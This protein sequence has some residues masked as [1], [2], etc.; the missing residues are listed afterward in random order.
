M[1]Q[2]QKLVRVRREQ[3]QKRRAEQSAALANN[4]NNSKGSRAGAATKTIRGIPNYGQTC[5]F[6]SVMQAMA[7]LPSLAVYL[8]HTV[9]GDEESMAAKLQTTLV[10]LNDAGRS[11]NRTVQYLLRKVGKT[12][13]QFRHRNEQQDAHELLQALMNLLIEEQQNHRRSPVDRSKRWMVS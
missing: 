10:A 13:A 8:Q 4:N 11:P 1:H 3:R 5:F 12:H 6:N 2:F 9:V 7:S